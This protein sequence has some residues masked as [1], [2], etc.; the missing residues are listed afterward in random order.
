MQQVTSAAF[1]LHIILETIGAAELRAVKSTLLFLRTCVHF[2]H[3]LLT[4]AHLGHIYIH[5]IKK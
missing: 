2:L 3:P 4:P 1:H 5:I